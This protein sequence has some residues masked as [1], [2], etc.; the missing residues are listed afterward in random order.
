MCARYVFFMGLTWLAL[1]AHFVPADA[2]TRCADM[3]Q[4]G[5]LVNTTVES[6]RPGQTRNGG[7]YCLIVAVIEASPKSRIKVAYRLP[8]R[9]NWNGRLLGLGG[10]GFAGQLGNNPGAG[11]F[12]VE[13]GFAVAVSD[14]GHPGDAV[15]AS[16]A[17]NDDQTPNY[18]AILDFADRAIHRM[19]VVAKQL[20]EVFYG[21]P[22]DYSYY[23]GCSTG[24]RMGLI[25]VQRY[26]HDFDGVIVGAPVLHMARVT[27]TGIWQGRA[28]HG[29]AAQTPSAAQLKHLAES[30]VAACD[31]LDGVVDGVLEDP[32]SC[33]W[34]PALLACGRESSNQCLKPAQLDAIRKIY[35]GPLSSDGRPLHVRVPP[36]GEGDWPYW[37]LSGPTGKIGGAYGFAAAYMKYLIFQDPSYDPLTQ[38]DFDRDVAK[39]DGS[40]IAVAGDATNPDIRPFI[41]AG[42]KLLIHHGWGDVLVPAL[43][44]VAY[45]EAMVE[46]NGGGSYAAIADSVRLFMMP[47]TY[48]CWGGPGAYSFDRLG[49]IIAWV[50]Q[51]KAPD[52]LIARHPRGN[53]GDPGFSR[54]LC[55]YPTIAR[56]TGP[57]D[58]P[59]ATLRAEN[60][61]CVER[62]PAA[63]L[64]R[65]NGRP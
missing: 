26:P 60:F 40:L 14:A 35:S 8:W 58:K 3:S 52:R 53:D 39:V 36:G 55:A 31:H 11:L 51:D 12:E 1:L 6:A 42:G 28:F 23:D 13:G 27:V 24:G 44:T 20:V 9:E 45:Y 18:A 17:L 41:A 56:F 29:S 48:H 22:A 47:G 64:Q 49:A 63:P 37:L 43:R 7:T 2:A 50:E 21:R 19:I 57:A 61:T 5:L 25:S 54:P 38:F 33:P 30:V 15:D 10:G 46:A 32:L 16:W 59:G 65:E 4:P 62:G 34:D